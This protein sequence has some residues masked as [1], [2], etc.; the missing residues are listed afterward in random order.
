M[1]IR[2]TTQRDSKA[3]TFLD[4]NQPKMGEPGVLQY[5]LVAAM[6]IHSG[7]ALALQLNLDV[8]QGPSYALSNRVETEEFLANKTPVY[9]RLKRSTN[10]STE[11]MVLFLMSILIPL[12]RGVSPASAEIASIV[13]VAARFVYA[14]S[15]GFGIEIGVRS[16][17]WMA[18]VIACFVIA[19]SSLLE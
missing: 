18:G 3:F 5:S 15:Y 14:L 16:F 6:V 4:L 8:T 17:S 2:D 13:Y 9:D 7:S 11:N 19:I 12:G 10:N 1:T